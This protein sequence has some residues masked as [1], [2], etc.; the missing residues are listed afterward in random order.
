MK[1]RGKIL[2]WFQMFDQIPL[3]ILIKPNITL[4]FKCQLK[5][6]DLTEMTPGYSKMNFLEILAKPQF[7]Y[8]LTLNQY[9]C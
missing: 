6:Q 3:E 4:S 2:L 9:F 8:F 7:L 5:N 1:S